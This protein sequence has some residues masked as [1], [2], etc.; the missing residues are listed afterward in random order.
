MSSGWQGDN[1]GNTAPDEDNDYV[2]VPVAKNRDG[3]PITGLV[4]GRIV[5][6]S[7]PDS[8]PML[9]N[10]NPVPYKPASLDT[11]QARR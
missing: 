3:S 8:R 4:I 9:V 7:G 6:A 2:T 11:T 10:A 1:S 5:N